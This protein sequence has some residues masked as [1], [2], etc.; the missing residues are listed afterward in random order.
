MEERLNALLRLAISLKATDIHFT[1]NRLGTKI[2]MRIN[3]RIRLVKSDPKDD[4][5]IRYLQYLANLDV[6]NLIKPQ[7]GQF[8]YLID[9]VIVSLRFALIHSAHL[10]NA[11]LR[12]LNSDLGL[13]I[14]SL[15]TSA[16]QNNFFRKMMSYRSGLYVCSGPTGSGKTTN[17][18]T[19]LHGVNGKKIFT[20]E[21]P[22]EMQ[23]ED[24]IQLNINE[25]IGF[26]YDEAIKQVLRHDPDIIMIGEIRDELTAHMAI[27][28]ANTG[29]TVI[30]SLHAP[31]CPLAIERILELKVEKGQLFNV[32]IGVSNQRLFSRVGSDRKVVIYETMD[33]D[34]IIHYFH[35]G[36]VS[37][38]F[39]TLEERIEDAKRQGI[40]QTSA[41]ASEF[42]VA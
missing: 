38:D 10:D 28:A 16:D 33:R 27:R 34:E 4:K 42:T 8:E 18:Y 37:G 11:V 36:E 25:A 12:I 31:S 17:L 21:D 13:N 23:Y 1:R 3:D 15:S 2:E 39:Y 6:G 5:M 35:Y 20:I 14:H 32:L 30:T 40:I 9:D 19:L 29:H 26:G 7:T 41:S 24:F 22:V